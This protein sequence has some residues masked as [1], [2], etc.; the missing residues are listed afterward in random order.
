MV[1]IKVDVT[2]PVLDWDG[3][4]VLNHQKV[5]DRGEIIDIRDNDGQPKP[6]TIR[7]AISRALTGL[8]PSEQE[9]GD[10]T[11]DIKD[12]IF[13]VM[14]LVASQDHPELDDTDRAFITS[15][16]LEINNALLHGRV[17][18]AIEAGEKVEPSRNGKGKID[19]LASVE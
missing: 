7:N 13:R 19:K 10:H 2:Q 4:T 17:T 11:A 6:F 18:E 16:S 8:L 1:T 9:R 14:C 15:R 3:T 12:D 5:G